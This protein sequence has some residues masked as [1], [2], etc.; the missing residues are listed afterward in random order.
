[1]DYFLLMLISLGVAA[2]GSLIGAGGGFLLMPLLLFLFEDK[3]FGGRVLGVTELSFISLFAVLVNGLA[4]TFNYA[5]MRRIDYK[6]GLVL[7]AC[8]IPTA[9]LARLL[10]DVLVDFDPEAFNPIFGLLLIAVGLF[11]LWRV[12]RRG[13][14]DKPV[15]P[16]PHWSHRKVVDAFGYEFEYSFDLRYGVG[17][18]LAEGFIASFFGIGGG[19]LHVPVMTQLLHFPAHV[20]SATSILILS[21][22]AISGVMTDVVKYGGDV[23]IGLALV[24]GAGAFIGAQIGT[25]LNRKVSGQRILGLLGL[26]LIIAGGKLLL[27]PFT[28]PADTPQPPRQAQPVEEEP[29]EA[30]ESPEPSE[31][32]ESAA[33]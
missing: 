7:A 16:K 9:I 4:A 29:E 33:P 17:A 18:S 19:I 14:D 28:K 12:S 26:A 1:M 11:I 31:P 20:A 3:T 15:T 5:R 21:V 23:P 24:A 22:G 8:T 27:D 13:A 2:F 30:A 32:V 6:T 10:L 25:R